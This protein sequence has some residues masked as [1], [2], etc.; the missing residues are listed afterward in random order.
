[1]ITLDE[2][3]TLLDY[4]LAT[5]VFTWKERDR[6]FFTRDNQW[7]NWNARYPGTVAGSVGRK[8]YRTIA[9]LDSLHKAHR[10]AWLYVYGEWPSDQIDH[11]NGDPDDNRIRN[12]RLVTNAE[13]SRNTTIPK[14]NSTGR[15]GVSP[16]FFN[17]RSKYLARIRVAGKL[18]HL[19]YFETVEE[20]SA[21]RQ[22]AEEEYGFHP[23]HGR[24]KSKAKLQSRGFDRTRADV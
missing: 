11:I 21:A 5:G 24:P 1:M 17:G 18:K 6:S 13:N 20:A 10:L 9:V 8:G 14:N 4:D 22:R 7:R 12:L 23:N 16:Y 19:G 15:I 3:K 2:V